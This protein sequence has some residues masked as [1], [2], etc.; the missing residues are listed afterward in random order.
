MTEYKE[1]ERERVC[2]NMRRIKEIFP[3]SLNAK[4]TRLLS[5]LDSFSFH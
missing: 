1:R 3:H 4:N 2:L 5:M